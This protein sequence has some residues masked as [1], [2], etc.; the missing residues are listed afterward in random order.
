MSHGSISLLVHR[1]RVHQRQHRSELPA[2]TASD[3]WVNCLS[4]T[5][6][7]RWLANT[8]SGK[9]W[10]AQ[11]WTPPPRDPFLGPPSSPATTISLNSLFWI[12]PSPERSIVG[13]THE[14]FPLRP[15]HFGP[16]PFWAPTFL[17]WARTLLA[18][19][20]SWAQLSW[21]HPSGPHLLKPPHWTN[22]FCLGLEKEK[23]TSW[24]PVSGR[25]SESGRVWTTRP[26]VTERKISEVVGGWVGGGS[27]EEKERG[28]GWGGVRGQTSSGQNF[29]LL[30]EESTQAL[31]TLQ[32]SPLH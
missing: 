11:I 2:A 1:V 18:P 17:V 5:T 8:K 22:A 30:R 25:T 23:E 13:F 12:T 10:P 24:M 28:S 7:C 32:R 26:E 3:L 27:G 6:C 15:P 14:A 9:N 31:I 21:P 20:S 16:P 4:E 19:H 29:D